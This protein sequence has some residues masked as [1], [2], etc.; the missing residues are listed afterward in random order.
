MPAC[1]HNVHLRE[2]CAECEKAANH[3]Q[4]HKGRSVNYEKMG[5]DI[6]ALVDDKQRQ[7]GDSFGRSGQIVRVLYPNGVAPHQM[8][9]ALAVVRVIDK[10][11][12]IAQRGADGKDL[13]GESPWRD[14]AGYG[15]LGAARDDAKASP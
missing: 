8:D 9:D 6:G 1:T 2:D 10:L 4:G 3:A 14:V 15:L 13:G 11:F 5:S 7:Y 12:R